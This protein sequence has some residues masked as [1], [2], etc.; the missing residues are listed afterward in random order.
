M[1]R[2]RMEF[3]ASML[4]SGRKMLRRVMAI[5][6]SLMA[7]NIEAIKLSLYSMD[8]VFTFG[9]QFKMAHGHNT[10]VNGLLAK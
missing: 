9:H 7:V 4:V 6:F 10:Q 1:A 5:V 8:K 2:M 3:S